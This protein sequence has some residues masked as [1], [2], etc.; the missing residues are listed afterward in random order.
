MMS[1]SA[2]RLQFQ[3]RCK[4]CESPNLRIERRQSFSELVCL[5]C[6]RVNRRALNSI[7]LDSKTTSPEPTTAPAPSCDHCE[8]LDDVLKALVSLQRELTVIVRVLVNGRTTQ[9]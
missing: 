8:Q 1:D 6:K 5:G 4:Y 3:S 9:C 7:Q 2:S